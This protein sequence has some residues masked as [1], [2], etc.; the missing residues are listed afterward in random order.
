M[1]CIVERIFRIVS[2]VEPVSTMHQRSISGRAEARQR[3]I[4]GDSFFTIM[5]RQIVGLLILQ[6]RWERMKRSSEARHA[7]TRLDEREGLFPL[8]VN[9]LKPSGT[10]AAGLGHCER[11]SRNNFGL[12]VR[13]RG[14]C[15]V[16]AC[17]VVLRENLQPTT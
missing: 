2:S 15:N 5:L 13:R 6:M 12:R 11:T 10:C 8:V 16:H 1:P 3:S 4:T 7:Q 9:P 17:L 14:R